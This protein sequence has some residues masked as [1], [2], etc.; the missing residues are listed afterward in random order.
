MCS[1]PVGDGAKANPHVP[2]AQYAEV[3]RRAGRVSGEARCAA[4]CGISSGAPVDLGLNGKVALVGRIEQG[5]SARHRRSHSRAEGCA[6]HDLARGTEA[7][8]E[9]RL[10]EEIRR[11]TRARGPRPSTSRPHERRGHPARRCSDGRAPSAGRRRPR[12][13]LRRP[14]RRASSRTLTD[15]DWRQAFELLHAEPSFAS[16]ARSYRTCARSGG[17]ASSGSSRAP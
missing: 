16:S 14:R 7:D 11:E 17:A 5:F 15:D 2:G 12:Q 3:I 13:Q 10:P 6:G 9:G 4:R 8:L 1:E